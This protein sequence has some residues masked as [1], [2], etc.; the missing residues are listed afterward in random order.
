MRQQYEL[1]SLESLNEYVRKKK[2]L[3]DIPSR[4]EWSQRGGID[5]SEMI[6]SLLLKVEELT[7]YTLEL[8]E[9]LRVLESS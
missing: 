8:N 6:R 7:L 2:H 3:P 5:H 9:R 1:R 4:A